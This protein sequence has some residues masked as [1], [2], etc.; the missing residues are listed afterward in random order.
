VFWVEYF[1][2]RQYPGWQRGNVPYTSFSGACA[3]ADILRPQLGSA[4]VIDGAG[5]VR[6]QTAGPQP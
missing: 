4:R 1:C 3:M 2:P 5:W 6:Y